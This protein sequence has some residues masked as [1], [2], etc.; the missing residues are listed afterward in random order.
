M[1]IS[2][3][4]DEIAYLSGKTGTVAIAKTLGRFFY[5]DTDRDET[6][7]FTD[8][9]DLIV[10]SAFGIGEKVR[11]GLKCTIFQLRE[12]EAPLIVLNKNHPAS[13]RLK[14]VVSIGACTR[15]SCHIRPGTHP[16]QDV[17]CGSEEFDGL[18]VQGVTGG[19]EIAGFS[20][21]VSKE[22]I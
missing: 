9:D 6:V 10:A 7:L 22:S 13:P 16:E 12:L 11:K 21:D 3:E 18:T 5:L 15:L 1:N 20:G 19:V 17:L 8:A 2:I 4:N 14:V